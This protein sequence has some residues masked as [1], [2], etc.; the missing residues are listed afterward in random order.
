MISLK[1]FLWVGFGGGIG[2]VLRYFISVNVKNGI[3]PLSTFF[4][5]AAGS[6]VI[7]L[8]FALSLKNENMAEHTRLFLMAGIC[9][10]FT[11]FSAFSLENMLLLRSG[12]YLTAGIYMIASAA[13]CILACFAGFKI[14]NH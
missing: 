12:N 7:G 3:F 5:N 11:T 8:V 13:V 14:I 10:G 2:A 9:G 6:L 4:I 1:N